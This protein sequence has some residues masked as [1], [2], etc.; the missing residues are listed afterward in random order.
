MFSFFESYYVDDT[1]CILLSRGEVIATSK[2]LITA[3]I[4]PAAEK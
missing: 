3:C 4:L 1:A 2:K